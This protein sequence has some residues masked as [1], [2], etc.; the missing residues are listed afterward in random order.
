MLMILMLGALNAA[1]VGI[2]TAAK[3]KVTITRSSKNISYK[4]GDSLSNKDEI[5][6][7]AESFAAY[8]YV[9]G[10]STIKVFSNSY[11]V[12]GA[13]QNGNTLDK[14]V[15]VNSGNVYT[16]VT[17]NSKGSVKVST[18]T[19]VASVKGTEFLTRVNDRGEVSYIVTKGTVNV[20]VVDTGES[21]DVSEGQTANIDVE[22]S[23][24]VRDSSEEDLESLEEAGL[25]AL[26]QSSTNILIIPMLDEDG[27]TKS[28]E[29]EY[30]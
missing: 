7:K 15:K 27:N 16:Q 29:I 10:S 12:I 19:T 30:Q 9:D 17:P 26:R 11:V 28:I 6:T 23:M 14:T 24:T 22:L 8:K 4:V 21:S 5:R 25:E 13:S 3:G 2:L 1:G 18:P 20:L